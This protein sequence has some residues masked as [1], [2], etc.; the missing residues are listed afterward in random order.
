VLSLYGRRC[1]H[2]RQTGLLWRS[3][4]CSAAALGGRASTTER[5]VRRHF[6][7]AILT[8]S[9]FWVPVIVLAFGVGLL[10]TLR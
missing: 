1:G 7:S 5:L 10:V 6:W 8:D 3:L 2:G 9:H 4:A